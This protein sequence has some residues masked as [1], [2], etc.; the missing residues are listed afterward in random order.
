MAE[1]TKPEISKE[2]VMSDIRR[3]IRVTE[4]KGPG[5]E[6]ERAAQLVIENITALEMMLRTPMRIKRLYFGGLGRPLWP[7]PEIAQKIAEEYIKGIIP[8]SEAGER[9]QEVSRQYCKVFKEIGLN[10]QKSVMVTYGYMKDKKVV[11]IR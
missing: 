2:T 5:T 10:P 1:K 4:T 3:V 8:Q 11:F 7:I 6:E 9:L